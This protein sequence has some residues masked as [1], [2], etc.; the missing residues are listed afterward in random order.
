MVDQNI[1]TLRFEGNTFCLSY[2]PNGNLVQATID[3]ETLQL[4]QDNL[5]EFVIRKFIQMIASKL[6][7]LELPLIAANLLENR[8]KV[9]QC[10]RNNNWTVTDMTSQWETDEE[11]KHIYGQI[12]NNE[13]I[14]TKG[15]CI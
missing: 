10:L 13:L 7:E 6:R 14:N 11:G 9:I 3:T 15:V 1:I 8:D 12:T 2:N 4:T 5:Q